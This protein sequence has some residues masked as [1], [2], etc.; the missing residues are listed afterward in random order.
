[1]ERRNRSGC[2]AQIFHQAIRRRETQLSVAD[3]IRNGAEIGTL[4]MREDHQVVARAL[5]VSQK[6]ILAVHGVDARPV[7]FA[8]LGCGNRWVL[9]RVEA[10]PELRQVGRDAFLLRRHGTSTAAPSTRPPRRSASASFACSSGYAR[11]C[12]RM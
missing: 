7:E 8:L 10:N 1:P 9:I 6:E 4:G 11:V 2:H 3:L 12:V 5:L